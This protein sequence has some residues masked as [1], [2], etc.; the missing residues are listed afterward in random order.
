[1]STCTL[2]NKKH[3]SKSHSI[4]AESI[5]A[6]SKTG[7]IK[8]AYSKSGLDKKIGSG[9]EDKEKEKPAYHKPGNRVSFQPSTEFLKHYKST[10]ISK[11]GAAAT[12]VAATATTTAAVTMG[13]DR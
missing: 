1:M 10:G 12:A 5:Q 9:S 6:E 7:T 13:R 11:T 3:S 4:Q 2:D 8:S